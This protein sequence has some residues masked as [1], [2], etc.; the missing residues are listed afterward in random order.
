MGSDALLSYAVLV[1]VGDAQQRTTH[2]P[3]ACEALHVWRVPFRELTE[4]KML[5]P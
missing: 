3:L 4:D 1:G 5:C 2:L